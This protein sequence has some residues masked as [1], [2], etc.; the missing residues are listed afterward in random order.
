MRK[1][2]DL[3]SLS[4]EVRVKLNAIINAGTIRQA[5]SLLGASDA[6]LAT[7]R[8]PYGAA[9]PMTVDRLTKAIEA[10]SQG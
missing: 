8:A 6:T 1:R 9:S 4:T 3:A 7:L 5:A 10:Y 2:G